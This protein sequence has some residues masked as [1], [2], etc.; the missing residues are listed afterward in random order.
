M[1]KI[2]DDNSYDEQSHPQV[3]VVGGGATGFFGA[4]SCATHNP[5]CRVTILEAPIKFC[6][7]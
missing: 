2:I 4:I 7:K 6:I 1:K 5:H 3:I